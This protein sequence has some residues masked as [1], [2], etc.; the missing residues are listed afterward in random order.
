MADRR[1]RVA[2]FSDI[3]DVVT[4]LSTSLRRMGD[5]PVAAFSSRG[6]P[7]SPGQRTVSDATCP[8]DL[9]LFLLADRDRLAPVLR[10][11]RPDAVICWAFAWRIPPEVL[12]I[13]RFGTV[14]YHPSLL[15][16]HRGPNPLAWTIR[17]GDSHFGVTWHRLVQEFDAGPI[18]AQQATPVRDEDTLGDVVPRLNVMAL[19]MLPEVMGMLASGHSGVPQD[20][21]RASQAPRFGA[22]YQS[23]DWSHSATSI[24]TQVRAWSFQLAARPGEGPTADLDGRRWRITR[25]SLSD[26]GPGARRVECA[27]APLW[28]TA[29]KL[30]E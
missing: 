23:I 30:F 10:T 12:E 25:T 4:M 8:S 13:P 14:N 29:G 28:I 20:E 6:G 1:W 5:E 2:L 18:M 16:R 7:R 11:V 15:P 27:D 21:D 9:D 24:H 26:P 3:A 22:D 17:T 19:R